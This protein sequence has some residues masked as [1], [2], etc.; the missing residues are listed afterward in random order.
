MIQP[1]SQWGRWSEYG[2][3]MCWW[4]M[5]HKEWDHW[6]PTLMATL[7]FAFVDGYL[8]KADR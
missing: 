1:Y 5:L 8:K 6:W 3:V 4:F 2:S 7:T